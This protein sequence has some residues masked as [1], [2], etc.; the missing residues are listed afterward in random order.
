MDEKSSSVV[1][2]CSEHQDEVEALRLLVELLQ[3]ND[4]KAVPV[5][6]A[7][8]DGSIREIEVGSSEAERQE[9]LAMV[10]RQLS[11]ILH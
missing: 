5:R 6:I 9:V 8:D 7:C 1:Q 11:R 4:G 2:L 3:S 10:R